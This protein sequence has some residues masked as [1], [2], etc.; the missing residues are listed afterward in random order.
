MGVLIFVN[1]QVRLLTISS[2]SVFHCAFATEIAF[3]RRGCVNVSRPKCS[4]ERTVFFAEYTLLHKI[5]EIVSYKMS[6][7]WHQIMSAG[8]EWI[9]S[10]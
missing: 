7:I 9:V 2:A 8:K 4:R 3:K 6:V 1:R 10:E 5:S